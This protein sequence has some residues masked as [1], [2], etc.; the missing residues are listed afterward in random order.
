MSKFRINHNLLTV[1][2]LS[3]FAAGARADFFQFCK[4][5]S[6]GRFSTDY[7][8]YEIQSPIFAASIGVSGTVSYNSNT[9]MPPGCFSA[10][11][12]G[13]VRGRIGFGAGWLGTIQSD[14]DD[15]MAFTWGF[16]P[17][18]PNTTKSPITGVFGTGAYAI[19]TED[20]TTT[21]FG[22]NGMQTAFVGLSDSYFYTRTTNNN[23]RI[24]CRVDLVADSAR[25]SWTLANV[26][27][28]SHSIGLGFGSTVSLLS[29]T[30]AEIH[31]GAAHS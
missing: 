27:V 13:N 11:H 17:A 26:D 1:A 12:T 2:L 16:E 23:V 31:E 8:G 10:H 19:V 5:P 4:G 7:L 30:R 14:V 29:E 21:M 3:A 25:V 9:E 15:S 18:P 20:A 24:D 28:V 22:A 6:T